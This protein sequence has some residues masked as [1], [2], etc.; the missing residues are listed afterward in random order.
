M[1]LLRAMMRMNGV[2]LGP[3]IDTRPVDP[4]ALAAGW[5]NMLSA[6]PVRRRRFGVTP[7]SIAL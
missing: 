6:E 7:A 2:P 4:D 5:R 3:G 1:A